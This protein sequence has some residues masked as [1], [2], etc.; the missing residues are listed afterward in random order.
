MLFALALSDFALRFGDGA[1]ASLHLC[2]QLRTFGLQFSCV[3]N[4]LAVWAGHLGGLGGG[5][6]FI[7]GKPLANSLTRGF[8]FT[9]TTFGPVDALRFLP[10]PRFFFHDRE[11]AGQGAAVYPQE[12]CSRCSIKSSMP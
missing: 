4:I 11:L 9:A 7:R 5:L 8:R 10:L 6:R 2:E 1:F 12:R 3:C